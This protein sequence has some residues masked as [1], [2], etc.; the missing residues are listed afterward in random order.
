MKTHVTRDFRMIR[1]PTLIGVEEL[2]VVD[3]GGHQQAARVAM[4]GDR[5][6]DVDQVHHGAAEDEPERVG[7]VRQHDLNHFGRRLRRTL[8][9]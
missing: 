9:Q 8:R 7:V 2:Q 6:G 4:A 1:S 5:A 3:G